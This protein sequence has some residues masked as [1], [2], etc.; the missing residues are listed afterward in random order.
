MET[1][2][3]LL[4]PSLLLVGIPVASCIATPETT[5]KGSSAQ[6]CPE[7]H[8][9]E[10]LDANVKVDARVRTFVQASADLGGA[11]T[12]LK[13]AVKTACGDI[14]SDLGVADTWTA[15]GDTDDA[16]KSACDAARGGIVAIM[17]AHRDAN[18]ALVVSRGECHTDFA[19][20][21]QCES[22]CSAQQKCDPGTVE[23][24]CDPAELSVVCS[25]NCSAQAFCEGHVDAEANCEGSCEAECTGHCSGS[26]TDESGHKTDNDANCHG[27]CKDHCSGTC[28]GR[29]KVDVAAG[30]QCGSNVSCK[31]G[32]MS[33]F[34][35]PKC[36]T[37][38]TPPKCMIDESCFESCRAS[39][40]AKPVCAPPTVKLL[41]DASVSADV[42]KLV[43][44]INKNL[45]PLIHSAEAQG[46]IVA[47]EVQNL[48]A[49]G[50]LVLQASGNLDLKSVACA[51]AA[52][53]SL[54]QTTAT[55]QVSTQA[56]AA[57]TSDCSSRAD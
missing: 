55:V 40:A 13:S 36:E 49:S 9:G 20:E 34:T 50:K 18:F 8:A 47:D 38:C 22:G 3:L 28:N 11:A 39:A 31:G 15:K 33:Q 25:G 7:F 42:A 2:R 57:V 10:V 56:G 35:E 45:P 24:R 43:A 41:A 46:R 21:A 16:I 14:A 1:R 26:C 19:A 51:T 6:G 5:A 53:E 37:E 17:D 48:G 32:C 4:L 27:K 52:A 29:C 12:A 30:V 23:T 54:A 44:T